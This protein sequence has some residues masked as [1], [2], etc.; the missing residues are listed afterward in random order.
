VR[1]ARSKDGIHFAVAEGDQP[2]S[3]VDGGDA[4]IFE[5][6]DGSHG[7]VT[8]GDRPDQ[9]RVW[10]R[11]TFFYT[12]TDL[13]DWQ[14]EQSPFAFAQPNCD[15]P[16]YFRFAG[17]HYFFSASVARKGAGLHGP[18]QDIPHT[19]LGVPKTAPW[20][21]GRRL[22]VGMIGDGGWGGDGGFHELLK[23]PDGTL[24]EKFVPE[25]TPLRGAVL[26]L[27]PVS[28]IGTAEVTGQTVTVKSAGEFAAAAVDGLPP[29]ARIRLT[30]RA[31][32]GCKT[33]GLTFRGKD[34]YAVGVALLLNPAEKTASFSHVVG[35]GKHVAATK[36]EQVEGL[37]QPVALDAIIGPQG[38]VD[39]ELNGR[40]CITMRGTKDP[41]CNRLF[42]F[43]EGG[44]VTFENIE[45]RPWEPATTVIR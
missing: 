9:N 24:G 31:A 12:S 21:D 1:I 26:D 4:D 32:A 28:L 14:E 2:I 10:Q 34:A 5:M 20:K 29:L 39:V 25:M 19:S 41:A 27:K 8:R 3:G 37:E 36:I 15:C 38:L 18:W 17:G 7:L 16:N 6:E 33:F 43:A 45:I 22:I 11:Q 23:L 13:K 42:L 44:A 35:P 40:Y 30:A